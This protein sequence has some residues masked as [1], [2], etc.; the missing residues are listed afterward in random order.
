[1]EYFYFRIKIS[2]PCLVSNKHNQHLLFA[3]CT[4]L[5]ATNHKCSAIIFAFNLWNSSKVTT[6]PFNSADAIYVLWTIEINTALCSKAI[7][8]ILFIKS[9]S[10][11]IK[12]LI[13][14]LSHLWQKD[15]AILLIFCPWSLHNILGPNTVF[16]SYWASKRQ[17]SHRSKEIVIVNHVATAWVVAFSMPSLCLIKPVTS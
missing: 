3:M 2:I 9:S 4:V 15:W 6:L 13:L 1:M 5:K 10:S 8:L 17:A 16:K 11:T 14:H 7:N 12:F